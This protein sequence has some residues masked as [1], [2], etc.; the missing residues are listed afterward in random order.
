MVGVVACCLQ[1]DLRPNVASRL[2]LF[3]IHRVNRVNY[4]N[5]SESWWQH[6]KHCPDII[7]VVIVIIDY[8]LNTN[9][10]IP[11]KTGKLSS[12]LYRPS[13]IQILVIYLLTYLLWRWLHYCVCNTEVAT[14]NIAEADEPK[15]TEV[16]ST[17]DARTAQRDVMVA[18]GVALCVTFV[19]VATIFIWH[20]SRHVDCTAISKMAPPT[21]A[22]APTGNNNSTKVNTTPSS[23]AILVPDNPCGRVHGRRSPQVP[24]EPRVVIGRS[25]SRARD[26]VT[27]A[28][29][30]L[31]VSLNRLPLGDLLGPTNYIPFRLKQSYC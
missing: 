11:H 1:A 17:A 29:T 18:V 5:D 27:S 28:S 12:V 30:A 14:T 25:V 20:S 23:G 24:G 2:A 6:H 13:A 31:H 8:L 15:I 10:V 26:D 7:T 3:C 21:V 4:C 16:I 9:V 19:A 22:V